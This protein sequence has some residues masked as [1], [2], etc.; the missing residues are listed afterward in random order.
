MAESGLKL[1]HAP[2]EA[3]CRSVLRF[4][5]ELVIRILRKHAVDHG[6]FFA[7]DEDLGIWFPG[8]VDDGS[9]T[10]LVV[11]RKGTTEPGITSEEERAGQ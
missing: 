6:Y 1:E 3:T 11:D 9:I 2:S 10:T 4:S 5:K 8:D 7:L